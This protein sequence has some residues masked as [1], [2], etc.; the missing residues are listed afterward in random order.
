MN[1]KVIEDYAKRGA[2]CDI[3][4]ALTL[5]TQAYISQCGIS[6]GVRTLI[7]CASEPW[8]ERLAWL[9]LPL[10]EMARKEPFVH[11]MPHITSEYDPEEY[12]DYDITAIENDELLR[13][14]L[15]EIKI[16]EFDN[17]TLDV[18]SWGILKATEDEQ[19]LSEEIEAK[20]PDGT[21]LK[22]ILERQ[23][24][25]GT[26]MTMSS[27]YN[28]LSILKHELVR[29]PQE[30]LLAGYN[31]Y[32]RLRQMESKVRE[33]YSVYLERISK[34]EKNSAWARHCVYRDVYGKLFEGMVLMEESL[35]KDW[36]GLVIE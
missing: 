25:G 36:W 30:L 3:M 5:L 15:Q 27:P 8:Q 18:I 1:K 17:T 33:L 20:V 6:L 32:Q 14:C 24:C 31:D 34:L 16:K 13:I 7:Y 23:N 2:Q 19:W 29:N 21:M 12:D 9:D 22:G 11:L 26:W 28:E 35:I 10:S 4:K